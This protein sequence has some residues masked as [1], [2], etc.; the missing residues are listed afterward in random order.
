MGLFMSNKINT[1]GLGTIV[2]SED[3]DV[4]CITE[5]Y[6][7]KTGDSRD[8]FMYESSKKTMKEYTAHIKKI[9]RAKVIE[10]I[11]G[12]V[13]LDNAR[14]MKSRGSVFVEWDNDGYRVR[15]IGFTRETARKLGLL[16]ETKDD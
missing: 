1:K 8:P 6:D 16:V 15:E 5:Q 11:W 10:N 12:N 2:P 7:R 4:F 3:H 14:W 13:N 9:V